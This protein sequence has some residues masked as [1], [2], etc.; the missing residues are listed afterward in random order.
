MQPGNIQYQIVNCMSIK[1]YVQGRGYKKLFAN[2]G[3]CRFIAMI[4]LCKV[5]A[6]EIIKSE[7]QLQ[8]HDKILIK[9]YK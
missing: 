8:S 3:Y 2:A 4:I 9:N 5:A 1:H 6:F 7:L